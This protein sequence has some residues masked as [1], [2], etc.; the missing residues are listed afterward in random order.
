LES[1]RQVLLLS[2]QQ[3]LERRQPGIFPLWLARALGAVQVSPAL[4]AQAAARLRAQ[5]L[6]RQ[7]ELKLLAQHLNHIQRS[8]AIEGGRQVL[9]PDLMLAP[10]L[11]RWLFRHVTQ[12]EPGIDRHLDLV[13]TAAALEVKPGHRPSRHPKNACADL[14]HIERQFDRR[15]HPI[16][17][18]LRLE[19]RRLEGSLDVFALAMQLAEVEEHSGLH[20]R[21]HRREPVIIP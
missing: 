4:G 5:R 7:R 1:A 15:R 11:C 12:L 8:F 3:P 19:Q 6:H 10:R 14:F 13:Q 20:A 16:V 18:V 2:I 17:V 9:V 21:K